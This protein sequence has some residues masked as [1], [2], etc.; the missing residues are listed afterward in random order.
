MIDRKM[1]PVLLTAY[2]MASALGRG[3]AATRA[4]LRDSRSALAKCA[5]DTVALDTYVG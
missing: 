2:T 1:Q 4:A 5:F 3:L